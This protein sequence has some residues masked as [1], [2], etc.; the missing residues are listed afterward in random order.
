MAKDKTMKVL[1]ASI[2]SKEAEIMRLR[3]Q[4]EALREVYNQGSG[5]TPALQEKS[6][7]P[8]KTTVLKLLKKVGGVGL[9]ANIACS[10]AR[11]EGI[12][13]QPKTVS[14][15]LSRFKSDGTVIHDGSK[16]YLPEFKEKRPAPTLPKMPGLE[17][18]RPLRTSGQSS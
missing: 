1:L 12:E 2:E 18:V 3:A 13:L 5:A 16:Y 10:L 11:D 14:S 8:V 7:L 6:S 17:V 15:L 4:I 9:N